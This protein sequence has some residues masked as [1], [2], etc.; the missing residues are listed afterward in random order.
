MARVPKVLTM[1]FRYAEIFTSSKDFF[2]LAVLF[3]FVFMVKN[4]NVE[5]LL[6]LEIRL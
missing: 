2:Y 3:A 5:N 4:D 1:N 6:H